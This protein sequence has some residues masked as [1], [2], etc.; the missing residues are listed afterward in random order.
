MSF[1]LRPHQAFDLD[2]VRAE[3]RRVRSCM[4]VAACG[5]GKGVITT[6]IIGSTGRHHVLFLVHGRDRVND[7]H[8]RLTRLGI[9]HGVLMG[10]RKRDSSQRVQVAS[11]DTVH[12]MQYKP[13]AGLIIIDECHLA[14]SPTFRA[15]LDEY[16]GAKILGLTAT[17]ALGNGSALGL[18][19]GGVFESMVVGPS[20]KQLVS[21]G[22]L[23]GSRHFRPPPTAEMAG[24]KKK[25]TG[26]FDENHGAAI[27][28]NTKV[29]GDIVAH[30]KRYSSD[31][32]TLS[33]GFHQAHA[34]HIAEQFRA[35]GV[36]WAYVDAKTSDATR[37]FLWEQYDHGD[38]VGISSCQTISIGW[39]HSICKS[40][41]LASKTASF[42]LYH[43]RL[44]RGSRPHPGFS[45]FLVLDHCGNIYEHAEKGPFFESDIQWALDG[46]AVVAGDK[47]GRVST[48]KTPVRVPPAGV[49]DSFTGPVEDGWL[50]PCFG[51]FD[52]GPKQCPFCGIPLVVTARE[53]KQAAGELEEV[54]EAVRQESEGMLRKKARYFELTEV[55]AARGYKP[56]YPAM[57]FKNEFGFWPAKG[58]KQ[59]VTEARNHEDR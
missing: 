45:D 54:T 32:K 12:R 58:W 5:Y 49:P 10:D 29:I 47:A 25:K 38:L 55:A 24:L 15:V 43:Q 30:W 36:N 19:S 57:A 1:T 31:R 6:K 4:L 7:M 27:A 21:E 28:D 56:G 42:P 18:A 52:P 11:S 14:M 23:V 17:P 3:L 59:Q 2:C 53:I 50:L 34:F 22:Y 46:E 44:G 40:L 13:K 48:C 9:S 26:E 35:A 16:P 33:F 39:D 41:I 51:G 20:V 8:D 37:K